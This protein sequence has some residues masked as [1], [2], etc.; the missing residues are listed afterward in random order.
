ME[1]CQLSG[2]FFSVIPL[3]FNHRLRKSARTPKFLTYANG[4]SCY[5]TEKTGQDSQNRM[6]ILGMGFVGQFFAEKLRN[7]GW[8]V[9]GTCTSMKKRNVLQERGLDVLLF[10][11]NQPE[12]GTMNT[13]KS[14]THLLVSIPPIMGIGDPMLQHGELLRS[15]M[16]DGNLQWLCY[17]SSTSIPF[18]IFISAVLLNIACI[19]A[20]EYLQVIYISL[21]KTY[22][23]WKS[24]VILTGVY[25]DCGGACVD[26]DFLASPTNEMAKL[27]L[28]AEQGWLNLAHDV[29]IKAH[30][31]RLGGI[32]GPGRSA[33]DTIIK[34]GP[35][36]ESQKRRVAK[37]FTSRVHVADICQALKASIRIQ[38]SRRIYNIVDDDPA[39]RK[40][41]FAYALDLVEKKWPSLVKE[42]T[43]HERAEPFVQK[44]T[45][46]GEK[47]VSNARM[48]KELAVQLLYPSYKSGLQSII[49]QIENPF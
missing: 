46:K 22:L 11:A 36:S 29:G 37:Q 38:L 41:V 31:F 21:I 30:V 44:T 19:N 24:T 43:S 3:Q 47:R 49:D 12:M 25:G 26:E 4:V 33:V 40:E 45:L 7:E 9:S 8:I 23:A 16:I 15:T 14:Y 32:Y 28:V 34:Q 35:L 39:S 5:Q 1:I 17:L 10:D 20:F 42:I 18:I 13:L 2:H 27:R 6:L 48:K